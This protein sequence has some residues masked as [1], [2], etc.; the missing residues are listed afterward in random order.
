MAQGVEEIGCDREGAALSHQADQPRRGQQLDGPREILRTRLLAQALQCCDI[1]FDELPQ[2]AAG[3]ADIGGPD[4][5]GITDAL[6]VVRGPVDQPG[7]EDPLHVREAVIAE[8]LGEADQ[9][10]GRHIGLG[11][12]GGHGF[13][14]RVIGFGDGVFGNLAQPPAELGMLGR[15]LLLQL[16]EGLLGLHARIIRRNK[17]SRKWNKWFGGASVGAKGRKGP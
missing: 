14:R 1:G 9:A 16:L 3:R 8:M 15:D 12:D 4:G 10:G 13:Q 7:A 2:D 11:R 6:V 17:Y 5:S